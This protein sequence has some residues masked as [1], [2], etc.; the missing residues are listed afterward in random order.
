MKKFLI[1][2]KENFDYKL[3]PE[4]YYS[5]KASENGKGTLYFLNYNPG[6]EMSFQHHD[7][8]S[9]ITYKEQSENCAKEYCKKTNNAADSRISRMKEVTSFFSAVVQYENKVMTCYYKSRANIIF[10]GVENIINL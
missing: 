7:E 9:A 6:G 5:I 10:P 2:L 8:V 4:P 1:L 3:L